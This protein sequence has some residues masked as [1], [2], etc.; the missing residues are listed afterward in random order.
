MQTKQLFAYAQLSSFF[1]KEWR[2]LFYFF[3]TKPEKACMVVRW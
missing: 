3:W 2:L 1:F